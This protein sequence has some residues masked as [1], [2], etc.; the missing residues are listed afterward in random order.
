MN[1]YPMTKI[2][3]KY[4]RKLI[5]CMIYIHIKDLRDRVQNKKNQKIQILFG[6]M[7]GG[8]GRFFFYFIFFY[9]QIIFFTWKEA[10]PGREVWGIPNSIWIFG[11]FY[12]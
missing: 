9:F 10:H 1:I 2:N 5:H 3:M 12:F 8:L 7:E 6:C 4:T 11:F